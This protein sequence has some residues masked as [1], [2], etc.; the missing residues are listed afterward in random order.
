M[1]MANEYMAFDYVYKTKSKIRYL[2]HALHIKLA[3]DG[4]NL[5]H[6]PRFFFRFNMVSRCK[7]HR[8]E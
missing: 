3:Y 7:E 6:F 2:L 8:T 4:D 5:F 1:L